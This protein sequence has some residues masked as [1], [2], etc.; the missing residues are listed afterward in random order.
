MSST[1]TLT[2]EI[3]DLRKKIRLLTGGVI[4]TSTVNLNTIIE[5]INTLEQQ[6]ANLSGSGSSNGSAYSWFITS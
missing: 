1:S 4:I 6:V 3:Q 5:D 2:A